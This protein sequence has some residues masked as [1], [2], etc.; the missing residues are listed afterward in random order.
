MT[1]MLTTE[2]R[3]A[4]PDATE[5][6]AIRSFHI[7]GPEEELV[8]LRERIAA[9]RWPEKEGVED[10]SQGV[11]LATIQALAHYWETEHDWRKCEAKLNSVPNFITEIDGL[12]IH[13]VHVRSEHEDA[14]P[15]IVLHGWP[16]SVIEQLKIIEPL[17]NPTAHGA[18]AAD[19]FHLVI[20]SMPGYGFSGKPAEAGWGP[21]HIARAWAELMERLGYDRYAASGGDWGGQ[22]VDL[23]GAQAP[24]GLIGIHTNFPGA[25]RPDVAAAVTSGGP[26]P[27][28]LDEEGTRLYEKLR[29]FFAT[30]VAYA[31][32][33]GTH[34]QTLYGIAASPARLAAWMLDHDSTPLAL[35]PRVS[36]L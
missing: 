2:P 26:A 28:G 24:L 15:L 13:F 12:D 23:M 4:E 34:P 16:G 7:D 5:E 31:L 33:L 18:S 1:D 36:V 25:V 30:D 9:T 29:D 11:Q 27:S 19:A 22:I 14:L 35:I 32:E 20:P 8:D 21:D 17:T 3:T 10:A 6:N